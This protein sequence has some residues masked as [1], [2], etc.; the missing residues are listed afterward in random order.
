METRTAVRNC[1]DAILYLCVCFKKNV[2]RERG[3]SKISKLYL[4][5]K[6]N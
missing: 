1:R 2:D 3:G 6:V 5:C 4:F